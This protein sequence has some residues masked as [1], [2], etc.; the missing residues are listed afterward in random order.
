MKKINKGKARGCESARRW[1]NIVIS[2]D[3]VPDI[4]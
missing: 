4:D 3:I 1:F 2:K